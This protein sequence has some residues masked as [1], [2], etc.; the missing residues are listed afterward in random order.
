MT[1]A[2][3]KLFISYSWSSPDHQQRVIELATELREEGV[4]VILDKWDLRE[5]DD[6]VAFM[7]KMVTDA[8]VRKV[9]I[10]CD[11]VYAAKADGRD[12]GVGTET[13]IISKEVYDNTQQNKFVAVV[14]ERDEHGQPC[15]PT[16]YKSRIYID[17]TDEVRNAQNFEQLLRWIF[18]KPTY[19]KPDLGKVP[20]FLTEP[21]SLS[22]GT[23][24]KHR[25]ALEA[26][27]NS[28]P[29]ASGA[30]AE[31]FETF[32][33]GMERF[34]ISGLEDDFDEK[35]VESIN[36]FLPYRDEAIEIFQTIARYS[37]SAL[38]S[39]I[40]P[41][42][43]HLLP[44]M[45]WFPDTSGGNDWD[46]DNYRFI[47]HELFLHAVASL[48]KHERYEIVCDLLRHRYYVEQF[49]RFGGDPLLHYS[50]YWWATELLERRKTRLKL[51]RTSLR[52]DM[53]CERCEPTGV[54]FKSLM[55]ADFV[56]YLRSCVDV[57]RG[58]S[59]W[60]Y[61]VTLVYSTREIAPFEIFARARSK[62]YF[63]RIKSMLGVEGKDDLDP[64]IQAL[65]GSSSVVPRWNYDNLPWQ[66]L[67]GYGNLATL[68]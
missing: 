28:R 64:V 53:L 42:F 35:M 26:I 6:A 30:L 48:I 5:G 17:L 8:D 21:D 60:W 10:L 33:G 7:E 2:N 65:G 22:L 13:Q 4:D 56:L 61:P 40:R 15:L 66:I 37:D 20:A 57:F 24:V 59:R 23:A 43:E 12:G 32:V 58:E 1:D 19:L 46:R 34:S 18:D 11:R 63:N 27:R 44:L 50:W 68:P 55:Q 38:T 14:M 45:C 51:S 49:A 31:Y 16:Y 39:Q 41:F 54:E 29:Y 36:G 9:A 67:L 47:I 3:P 62:E 52:A 25:R